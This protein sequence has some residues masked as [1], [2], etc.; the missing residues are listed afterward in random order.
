MLDLYKLHIFSITVQEGS[1]RAAADRLY[2]TQSAVSQHIKSL[3]T[4]LGCALFERTPQGVN[5]TPHGER[6]FS[7]A[8]RI[9]DLVSEAENAL[10]DVERLGEGKVHIAATFGISTYLAPDWVSVFRAKYPKLSVAIQGGLPDEVVANVL[11]GRVELGFVEGLPEPRA[12][13]SITPIESAEQVL[14]VGVTHPWADKHSTVSRE[15]AE[16]SFVTRPPQ[17][18]GRQWLEQTLTKIGVTPRISAEFDSIEGIKRALSAGMC[19]SILPRYAVQAELAQGVL[20]EVALSDARLN[21]PIVCLCDATRHLT[22][23]AQ[24]FVNEL[25]QRYPLLENIQKHENK[26]TQ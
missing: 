10:T 1:F 18:G 16:Q 5:L 6:L 20:R 3:E 15:L 8:K 19:M 7:Y 24:A 14:V 11:S 4:G 22:P 12:G 25:R 9:F 13:L 17:S 2:I 26:R 23:L 21:R